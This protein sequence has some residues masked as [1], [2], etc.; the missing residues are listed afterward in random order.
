[1]EEIWRDIKNY[2]GIYQVSN[3]GRVKRLERVTTMFNQVCSWQQ[4]LPEYIFAPS[5]DTHGY[6]QVSLTVG[7]R[8]V[9]R[10]HRLVAEAFLA[11]PSEELIAQCEL[12]GFK[13][14]L[15]NHKDHNPQNNAVSNLEWC[16]P[17]YNNQWYTMAG[18]ASK[19]NN[20]SQCVNAKLT[21]QEALEIYQQAH[22]GNISQEVIAEIYGVKQITVSNIK[23]GRS[24]AWL[25]GHKRTPRHKG[26]KIR[27]LPRAE[28]KLIEVH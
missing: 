25:T 15:V 5:L 11:A 26:K 19:A 23:T 28:Q 1:M 22:S 8:R 2:E 10:V 20:G 13:E 9:A 16:T 21:E 24:W 7:H 18:R 3:L 14:V 27:S 12:T 6:P 4:S 17:A